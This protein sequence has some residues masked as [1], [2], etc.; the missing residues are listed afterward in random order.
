MNRWLVRAAC[1]GA[2]VVQGPLANVVFGQAAPIVDLKN[3]QP[4]EVKAAVFSLASPQDVRI[5]AIGAESDNNRGMFSWVTTMWSGRQG[6]V[7]HDP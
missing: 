3:M 2:L 7:R 6:D 4:H 1:T 5:D